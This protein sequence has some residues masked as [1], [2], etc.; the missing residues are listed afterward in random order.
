MAIYN[1]WYLPK[2][3]EAPLW[4][5]CAQIILRGRVRKQVTLPAV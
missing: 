3:P 5:L 2:T 1:V 4:V